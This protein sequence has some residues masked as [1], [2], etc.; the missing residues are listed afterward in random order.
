MVQDLNNHVLNSAYK[1][2]DLIAII[3][4]AALIRSLMF[5]EAAMLNSSGI[6]LAGVASGHTFFMGSR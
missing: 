2:K 5:S 4:K 3:R 6:H 1:Q